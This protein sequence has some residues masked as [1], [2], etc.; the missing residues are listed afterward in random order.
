VNVDELSP[1]PFIYRITV[2]LV[3]EDNRPHKERMKSQIFEEESLSFSSISA[4]KR[5]DQCET[6]DVLSDPSGA[7]FSNNRN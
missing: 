6:N 7:L 4:H 1:I 2:Q 5:C 3:D